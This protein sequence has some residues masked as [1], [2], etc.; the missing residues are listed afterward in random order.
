MGV[1]F[2]VSLKG[3]GVG[4]FCVSLDGF[5]FSGRTVCVF[6]PKTICFVCGFLY[7]SLR[8]RLKFCLYF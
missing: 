1:F 5:L 3:G 4:W 8:G 6:F 7:G 2:Y